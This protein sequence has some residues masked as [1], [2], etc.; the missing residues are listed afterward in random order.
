MEMQCVLFKLGN[1]FCGFDILNVQEI[2]RSQEHTKIPNVPEFIEGVINLR[3]KVIPVLNLAKKF[4]TI[5]VEENESTRLIVLNLDDTQNQQIAI[6]VAEVTEVLTIPEEKVDQA[7]EFKGKD[8]TI[9]QGIAKLDDKL[10]M[11]INPAEI[12][13][14]EEHPELT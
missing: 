13:A 3:G 10:V 8:N 12:I 4:R 7:P 9:L 14:A 6:K 2:V 5:P 11:I 1:E